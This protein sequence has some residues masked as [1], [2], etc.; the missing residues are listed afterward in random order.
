VLSSLPVSADVDACPAVSSS[1]TEAAATRSVS[2]DVGPAV[3][4]LVSGLLLAAINTGTTVAWSDTC[5]RPAVAGESGST[6]ARSL[7]AVI[8]GR[9]A[10][11]VASGFGR[12]Q[13]PTSF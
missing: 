7:C 8:D 3:S 4:V 11:S 13:A 12:R 6:L 2:G 10:V 5:G 1:V 9:P